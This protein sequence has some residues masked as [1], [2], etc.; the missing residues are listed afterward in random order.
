MR[1]YTESHM[2][3]LQLL[4]MKLFLFMYAGRAFAQEV[5]I[6]ESKL[7]FDIPNFSA[8]LTFLVKGFFVVAGLAALFY[9]LWGS[10]EWVI[11]GGV[12]DKLD[13]A[14]K[15]IVAALVG[16]LL[17]VMTLSIVAT[18]ETVVFDKRLCFGISCPI[19]LPVLLG[20]P[21]SGN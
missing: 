11:S 2:F 13:E 6:D 8:I 15:K 4:F 10:I 3:Y 1:K 17:I 18:L 19:D 21:I 9:L 7:N 20:P 12:K 5:Q 16:V 14:R